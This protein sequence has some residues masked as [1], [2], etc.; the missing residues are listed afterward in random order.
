MG[1]N[2]EGFV[3]QNQRTIWPDTEFWMLD[4]NPADLDPKLQNWHLINL[5]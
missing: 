2:G 5:F 4:P 3:G 1:Y